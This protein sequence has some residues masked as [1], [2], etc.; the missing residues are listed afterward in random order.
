[1]FPPSCTNSFTL[2]DNGTTKRQILRL[3]IYL[4]EKMDE[5]CFGCHISCT[6]RQM[7]VVNSKCAFFLQDLT[8][9]L[10]WACPEAPRTQQM[11]VSSNR[12]WLHA[13][14]RQGNDRLWSSCRAPRTLIYSMFESRDHLQLI[15]L[16]FSMNTEIIY[17]ICFCNVCAETY[18]T[19]I[20]NL[21]PKVWKT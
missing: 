17:K 4:A 3:C 12:C 2:S 11:G 15:L 9:L 19:A 13:K 10:K 20:Q 6:G 8:H 16:L 14:H 18:R 7:T 1:M 5:T 21:K